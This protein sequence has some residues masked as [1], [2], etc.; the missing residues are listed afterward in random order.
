M[1]YIP[2][3][4]PFFFFFFLKYRRNVFNLVL[5]ILVAGYS[6]KYHKKHMMAFT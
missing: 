3:L 5:S 2:P 1:V 6:R 4:K